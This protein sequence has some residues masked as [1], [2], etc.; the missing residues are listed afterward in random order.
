MGGVSL[1]Q[2]LI[3]DDPLPLPLPGSIA[4]QGDQIEGLLSAGW[5]NE[6]HSSYIS[7]MEA[8]FV[9]QLYG[10]ENCSYDANKNNLR[11]IVINNLP[12]NPWVRRFK[13]RG[14]CVNHRG[15]GMEP[16]VDD[17]GS[18]TDTVREKVRTHAGVV[19][20]SVIIGKSKGHYLVFPFQQNVSS[21]CFTLFE[22]I[23]VVL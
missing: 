4:K 23:L 5:T 13:P 18:G 12:E 21:I 6:R 15:I 10:Q 7:S 17:Y 19:K 14:A 1:N 3:N 11:N 16:I 9:E 2:P 20:T 22:P 8:S